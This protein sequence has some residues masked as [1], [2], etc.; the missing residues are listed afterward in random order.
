MVTATPGQWQVL[1]NKL[2]S[3]DWEQVP[4]PELNGG[5]IAYTVPAAQGEEIF[6][7]I[8]EMVKEESDLAKSADAFVRSLPRWEKK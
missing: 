5:L 3:T 6:S 2:I 7:L 1:K 4:W 8:T